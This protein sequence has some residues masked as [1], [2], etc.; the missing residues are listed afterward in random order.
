MP[1]ETDPAR[2]VALLE[3]ARQAHAAG[4]RRH[5]EARERWGRSRNAHDAAVAQRQALLDAASAGQDINET[6][7]ARADAAARATA[8]TRDLH[9]VLADGAEKQMHELEAALLRATVVDHNART[10]AAQQAAVDAAVDYDDGANTQR[11]KLAVFQD[12]LDDLRALGDEASQFNNY[13]MPAVLAAN[14]ALSAQHASVHPKMTTAQVGR[15]AL[16]TAILIDAVSGI[17]G[18]R[19]RVVPTLAS[20]AAG[21]AP[22]TPAPLSTA[23]APTAAPTPTASATRTA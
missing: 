14:A 3:S 1:T 4:V 13:K 12:R 2:T 6:D 18:Q 17:I 9:R 15:P 20:Y 19:T 23:P 16:S 8:D 10:R 21:L 5:H 22:R 11:G 7:L